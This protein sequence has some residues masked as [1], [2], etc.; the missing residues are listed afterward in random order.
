MSSVAKAA[1]ISTVVFAAIL[2]AFLFLVPRM[3]KRPGG[4]EVFVA[5]TDSGEAAKVEVESKEPPPPLPAVV[6]DAVKL[7]VDVIERGSKRKLPRARLMVFKS[8]GERAGQKVWESLKALT[9][10]FEIPLEAGVYLL[11]AQC[12]RYKGEKRTLTLLKDAPQSLVMELDR[13]DSISGR[14]LAAGGS[15]LGG[16]RVLALQELAAPGADIEDILI[17]MIT[18]QERTNRV[19]S[20]TVSAEDGTY[21]LDGLE[22]RYYTVRAIAQGYAPGEVGEVPAPRADVDVVLQKGGVVSGIVRD[23]AGSPVVGASIKAYRDIDSAD[24]FQI[25]MA[26]ARPAVDATTSGPGGVFEFRTLGTG[27]FG[28]LIDAKGYQT[29]RETKKKITGG[30]TNILNFVLKPGQKIVGIVRGPNDEP[31]SGARVRANVSGAAANRRDQVNIT[32][33]DDSVMTDDQGNFAFDTLE[34]GT[35]MLLCWHP[36]Y[37]TVRRQDVRPSGDE[38]VLK[39]GH[40]GRVRGQILNVATG[41][42][43]VGARVAVNDV[44]DLNK[45]AVSQED[46]SF[47]LTGLGGG[48]ARPVHINVTAEGYGRLRKEVRI[49]EG[50]EVEETFE[51]QPTASASGVVVNSNND[52]VRGA[53]VTARKAQSG[54][55][56]N[57][58]ATSPTRTAASS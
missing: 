37:Q 52:P 29:A 35:F 9:G 50:R 55:E 5:K 22:P 36:D 45:D 8:N 6:R 19:D 42:P 11:H 30:N 4:P 49:E 1:L 2:G 28:F 34:D 20:E 32:F 43:V 24:V 27:V 18:I 53:R 58:A 54:V 15:P 3:G 14:V 44:A 47:V 17:E 33:D 16:A 56:Q 40:G 57:I 10:A 13:G 38:I 7:T 39:M 21:Q 23:A 46:G 31:V 12:P 25:I 48:G 41:Q 51:L 26:K